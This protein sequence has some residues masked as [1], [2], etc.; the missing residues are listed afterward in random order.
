MAF[1]IYGPG[2]GL[3]NGLGG[4]NFAQGDFSEMLVSEVY[5]KYGILSK[6]SKIFMAVGITTSLVIFSTAAGT[7]GPLLWNNSSNLNAVLLGMS[8]SVTTASG[9]SGAIGI[10]TG[11]TTA[12]GSTTAVDSSGGGYVGG[13]STAM[14]L[15]QKGTVSAAASNFYPLGA[16]H[17]GAVTVDVNTPTTIWFDGLWTIPPGKFAAISASATLTSAVIQAT[18]IWAELPV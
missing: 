6:N 10:A 16:V 1:G 4:S 2:K 11:T 15:Y 13:A 5:P 17:T 3:G 8:F 18:L 12:P 9:V 7:G 14:T